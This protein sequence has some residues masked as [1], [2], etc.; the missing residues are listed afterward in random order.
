MRQVGQVGRQVSVNRRRRPRQPTVPSRTASPS[1]RRPTYLQRPSTS[2]RTA[3]S[4]MRSRTSLVSWNSLSSGVVLCITTFYISRVNVALDIVE[5]V[6]ISRFRI[7]SCRPTNFAYPGPDCM[8]VGRV[9]TALCCKAVRCQ[10]ANM[11]NSAFHPSG[12]VNE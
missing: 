6:R 10:S 3:D 5:A 7:R 11:A 4:V 2:R 9:T 8:L 12:S 1:C